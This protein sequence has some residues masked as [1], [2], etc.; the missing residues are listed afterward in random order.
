MSNTSLAWKW[1]SQE[2]NWIWHVP[3]RLRTAFQDEV[4]NSG[5]HDDCE[6]HCRYMSYAQ[7][8]VAGAIVPAGCILITK[9]PA[10]VNAANTNLWSQLGAVVVS[11]ATGG[12]A[13]SETL[14]ECVKHVCDGK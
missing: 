3:D 6:R 4:I 8:F 14:A 2:W 7:F 11:G 1:M 13:Q 12:I 5:T 10:C 9:S